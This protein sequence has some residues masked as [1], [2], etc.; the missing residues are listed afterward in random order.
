MLRLATGGG[1]VRLVGQSGEGGGHHTSHVQHQHFAKSALLM[2]III[3]LGGIYL[4]ALHILSFEHVV[5]LSSEWV[6]IFWF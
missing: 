5:L 1:G 6:F 2:R 3:A 4:V